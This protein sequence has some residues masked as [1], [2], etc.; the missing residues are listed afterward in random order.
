MCVSNNAFELQ[1]FQ[2]SENIRR[3]SIY[4][5]V[6]VMY[7][8]GRWIDLPKKDEET[9]DSQD[10]I[11]KVVLKDS[12]GNVYE[13]EPNINGLSFAKGEITYEDYLQLDKKEN[14]KTVTYLLGITGGYLVIGWAFLRYFF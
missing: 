3:H 13:V 10:L 5:P 2:M 9:M 8:D 12:K 6:R 1:A 7:L 14:K 4:Q 11:T